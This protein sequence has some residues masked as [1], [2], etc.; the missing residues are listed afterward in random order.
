MAEQTIRRIRNLPHLGQRIVKT[1]V[2]VFLC[3]VIYH[4]RGYRSGSMPVEAAITAIVCMQPVASSAAE[5]A[6]NRFTATM[7]GAFWGI[8]LIVLLDL[9]P[10]F[11]ASSMIL[12]FL[13]A[14]GV[15][16]TLYSSVLLHKPDT[17]ALSAITFLCIVIAWPFIESPIREAVVRV[18][19]IMI[20][21]IVAVIVNVFRLPRDYRR[22]RVFFLFQRDLIPGSHASLSPGLLFQLN[23]LYRD[24]ARI[25][26]QSEH[27]P[28]FF[29]MQMNQVSLALPSIVMDGTAIFDTSE[30]HYLWAEHIS[31][32]DSERITAMLDQAGISY[33]V[34][35][36]HKDRICIFHRGEMRE[37]ERIVYERMRRSP[38]RRYLEEEI[39]DP[40]QIVTIKV[41]YD[42]SRTDEICSLIDPALQ[43]SQMR[44]VIRV[45]EG[46]DH[47]R[48]LYLY[49]SLA[50]MERAREWIMDYLS[51]DESGLIPQI[52]TTEG[53]T[54][55][56]DAR[57][58][59]RRVEKSYEPVRLPLLFETPE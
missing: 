15:L 31:V 54:D 48:A 55:E 8:A 39:Y 40:K 50:T 37:E 56:R 16:L 12:Y 30:N 53:Y 20:G 33:F 22:E 57:E 47:L 29:A 45:Q 51:Q 52:I 6:L 11:G 4:M 32:P 36:I 3:L 9:V 49:N 28:A 25:C 42:E 13:M 23:N 17:S 7:I 24:G 21:T 10:A 44:S 34:Y 58:L 19:D 38:Y 41:I 18:V 43:Q 5:Y 35:T 2:A 27:A 59:L 14:L 46:R 1:A 26:I